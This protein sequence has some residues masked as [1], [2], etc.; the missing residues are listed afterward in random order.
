MEKYTVELSLIEEEELLA[1]LYI[2]TGDNLGKASILLN[3]VKNETLKEIKAQIAQNKTPQLDAA[4]R[5]TAKQEILK[6]LKDNLKR[7][8]SLARGRAQYA[9]KKNM[10]ESIWCE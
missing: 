9:L 1:G 2:L 5:E 7:E 3:K 4:I 10:A 8:L 6:R